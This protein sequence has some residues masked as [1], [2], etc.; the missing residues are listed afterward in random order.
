[1]RMDA[2]LDTGPIVAQRRVPVAGDEVAPE[3][4]AA[5]ASMA[6]DLLDDSLGPW[7]RG[8]VP[9]TPQAEDGA[10]L[11]RPL[12][13][14]DGRLDPARP[15]AELERQ[16][17]AYQPW[18]GSFV[19]TE[20]GRIVVWRASVGPASAG[21]PGSF[22]PGGLAT[23]G[24]R[25]GA[26]RGPA[27]RRQADDLGTRSCAGDPGIV[28]SAALAS[29]SR[30]HRHAAR[31]VRAR[32]RTP[33]RRGSP[34][35]AS[36]PIAPDRSRMPSGAGRSRRPRSCGRC[37]PRCAT[38]L[39]AEFRFDTVA[40]TE[41]QGGRRRP[42]REGAPSTRRRRAHRIGADALPGAGRV[43]RAA[44]AVHLEPGRL[45]GRLSVLRD[46]RARLRARPR[47]RRDRRPGPPRVAPPRS[48]RA[49][50]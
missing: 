12:R 18:P 43:A 2:G 31:P 44:H 42:D 11:T 30:D 39:E 32:P 48:P 15:A 3:L 46:R 38:A 27:G 23:R 6:A 45:R 10:T 24:R 36:P 33:S 1:M 25:A 20:A 8:E 49:S 28:G 40:D 41:L 14:E 34:P 21:L 37:P 29:G 26:P 19:D 7:L 17:R 9:P 13:R 35:A 22:G 16:V 47:G 5:L 4:E 50:G